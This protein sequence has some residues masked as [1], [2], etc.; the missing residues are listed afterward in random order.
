MAP[1]YSA[2]D[3]KLIHELISI[4]QRNPKLIKGSDYAAPEAPEMT[5]RSWKMNEFKYYDVPSPFPTLARGLFT[6]EVDEGGKRSGKDKEYRIVVRGY[7]K[8]FNIGEVPW[9]TWDSLEAHTAAPYTLSLK[10]NGCI[11]FIAALTPTKLLITSKHSIGPVNGVARSHSRVGEEWLHKHL[12]KAGKTAEQL[13]ATL[14]EKNWTAI[15]ELC[16]DDF[17]EHVLA[18][19]PEKSGLHLHGI[20]EN[21]KDF[22]T[23]HTDVVDE[24]ADEWGFIKTK[25]T[26]LNSI[27][28]VRD[29]TAEIGKTGKWEGEALE[30][31]VVRTLVTEPPTGGNHSASLSPY[32]PGSSFFFKVKFDEP[33][34]MYRDWREVTKILLSTKGPLNDARLPK[35]KLKRPETKLY[36]KWIKAE[37]GRDRDQFEGFNKGKG[38]IATRE[39]FIKWTETKEAREAT[40]DD[41]ASAPS[42]T[43]GKTVILPI[44]IP[45]AGKTSVSVALEHLFGFGHTQSDDVKGKKAAT[46]FIKNV[47]ALL[48]KHNVVIADKNNHMK[49]HR[50]AL[51]DAVRG[52]HPPVRLLAL[53]WALEQPLTAIHK[54]CSD[55]INDRGEN[56]QTLQADS[57][58]KSHEA[59]IWQ[60]IEQREE[61]EDGE[62]DAVIEMDIEE[63][64]ERAL[65]RAVDG[66]V[67][68][69]GLEKPDQEKVGLALAAARRYEPAGKKQDMKGEGKAKPNKGKPRYYGLVP[70]VDLLELLNPVFSAGGDG[71]VADGKRFFTELK[72]N[73]RITKD[74]HITIVHS[75]SL[76]SEW[77]QPLWDRC[78]ELSSTPSLFRFNLGS[79]VWND[80]V[81]AIAVDEVLPV[82][83]DDEAGRSFVDQLPQEVRK[84][85]HITVGTANKDIMPFEA[86]AL[87]E[88]W[89]DGKRTKSLQLTDLPAE[90]RIRGLF[91]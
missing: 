60:F 10:S 75:K 5:I 28:E 1:A 2:K 13:A 29:F 70:E 83:D 80:R 26:V 38:I 50:A 81:M 82:A 43:Y 44:A 90:G 12:K 57:Y 6:T 34:M 79:V 51:R 91:A 22:R 11:I 21:T 25:T 33:Y 45:G 9:T 66:C 88:E 59:V 37:I 48:K 84:K 76:D 35:A 36:V 19:S 89:R 16:D 4:S 23:Q 49:Q 67:R 15:S 47:K 73:G 65:D 61:L 8:F 86:H 54:I 52:S 68:I 63:D 24:F 42:V 32:A 31:F 58:G 77:A 56:H 40:V 20:N 27:R 17:E 3:N 64:L 18:Y 87:V 41:D 85:L 55:R 78:S 53:N 69:L 39:R 7:D 71:D 46:Q 72:K 62:V 14:W 30:G 74:P